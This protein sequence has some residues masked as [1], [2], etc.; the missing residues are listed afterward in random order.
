P[1]KGLEIL[2]EAWSRVEGKFSDWDLRLVGPGAPEYRSR[3][4]QIARE[5]RLERVTF[6]PARYGDEKA[7]EYRG[8]DLYVLPSLSENF[9]MSVAEALAHGVPVLATTGTPWA[10]LR[11][12]AAGWWVPPTASDLSSALD[13]A[14]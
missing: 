8:S 11:V 5:L 1:I 2:L 9:A 14:L 10:E 4:Q 6:E 13:D 12:R 7:A 3:L